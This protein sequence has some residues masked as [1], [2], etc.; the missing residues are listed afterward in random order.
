VNEREKKEQK[1]EEGSESWI[2][3]LQINFHANFDAILKLVLL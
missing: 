3:S 2:R 1:D